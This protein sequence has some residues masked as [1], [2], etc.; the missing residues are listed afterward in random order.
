MFSF[1]FQVLA[2]F[3]RAKT[4]E[5]GK[6]INILEAPGF[7]R[8]CEKPKKG[9][10]YSSTFMVPVWLELSRNSPESL[11]IRLEPIPGKP[12]HYTL[13]FRSHDVPVKD[14]MFEDG[15]ELKI[16]VKNYGGKLQIESSKLNRTYLYTLH[17]NGSTAPKTC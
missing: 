15:G 14:E 17:W 6:K 2:E 13:V 5:N 9:V 7:L 11:V 16:Q 4:F 3:G 1:F 8:V 12:D 10:P